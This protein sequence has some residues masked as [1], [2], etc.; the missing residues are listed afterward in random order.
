MPG[1]VTE[2]RTLPPLACPVL[3]PPLFSAYPAPPRPP[4]WLLPLLFLALRATSPPPRCA[5]CCPPPGTGLYTLR[6]QA[7]R[8]PVPSAPRA[9]ALVCTLFHRAYRP[10]CH[11][12]LPSVSLGPFPHPPY[13][14]K[15]DR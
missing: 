5:A 2:R 12:S 3:P 8:S 13:S 7:G 14:R 15:T 4:C 1:L 10:E 9:R 11:F 6:S